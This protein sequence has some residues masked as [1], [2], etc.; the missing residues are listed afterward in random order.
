MEEKGLMNSPEYYQMIPCELYGC[1]YNEDGVCAYNKSD[2]RIRSARACYEDDIEADL[3][4]AAAG[5]SF[6]F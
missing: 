4:A 3:D 5:E 6:N 1:W 2:I